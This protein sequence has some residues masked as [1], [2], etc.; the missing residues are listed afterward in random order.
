MTALTSLNQ[1]HGCMSSPRLVFL[2]IFPAPPPPQ[3]ATTTRALRHAHT[4][5]HAHKVPHFIYLA[6]CELH[7]NATSLCFRHGHTHSHALKYANRGR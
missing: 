2:A 7:C 6:Q 4:N 1:T 3:S 5:R